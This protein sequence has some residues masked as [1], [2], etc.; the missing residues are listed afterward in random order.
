M[1][2]GMFTGYNITQQLRELKVL[3]VAAPT[4]T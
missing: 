4:S 1:N 2:S 3:T